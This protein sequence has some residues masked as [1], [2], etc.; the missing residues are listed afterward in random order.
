M[1]RY[2]LHPAVQPLL[3]AT[4]LVLVTGWIYWPGVSGPALLDDRSSVLVLQDLEERPEYAWDYVFGNR[5]GRLG[6]PVSMVTF[7]LERVYLDGTIATSKRVNIV[8]HLCNGALVMWLFWL[9][10]R[11]WAVPGYRGLA[12]VL[13]AIWLLHPLL[14]STVL[15]VVQRMAM[16]STFF[17]LLSAISYVY[18]RTALGEGRGSV[19]RFLPVP[20]CLLL[21]LFAKENAI[22]LIPILLLMEVLWFGCR[23]PAGATIRWL[24]RVSVSLI[25]GGAVFVAALLLLGWDGLAHRMRGRPFTLDE[26]LLT[27]SRIVWDYVSQWV[28]PQVARMGIYHDDVP[29]SRSLLE[30]VTTLYATL[31]WAAVMVVCAVLLR[32][33]GGRWWVFGFA[34]FLIGHS[35]ESTVFSLELYYEHRNYFPSI[36]LVLALGVPFALLVNRW[37]EPRL[38]L[39]VCLGLVALVLSALTSSQAVIWS[40]RPLLAL[41]H[42]NG[43]P[44][45][46]RANIEMAEQVARLGD[47]ASAHRYSQAAFESSAGGAGANELIGDYQVRNL[48]LNC[49]ANSPPSPAQ[50]EALALVDPRR[51]LQSVAA[52]RALVRLLQGGACPR[53]DRVYV[54]DWLARLYLGDDASASASAKIYFDLAL[55]ENALARYDKAFAYT[56]RFLAGAPG[57]TRGLLMKLHFATATGQVEAAEDA[58]GRLQTMQ[59]E[60]T[61]TLR[62]QQTLALYL[63]DPNDPGRETPR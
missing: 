11:Y 19:L 16:L 26:R 58:I 39:L 40:S 1:S 24:Q 47:I 48:A 44:G 36:G 10:F 63:N 29:L 28:Y 25:A 18:W 27:Q 41:H 22:V 30:P 43:H 59:R 35:I 37:P 38:A 46:G 14:V 53:F 17:M 12:V 54:A 33:Q 8:V 23:T 9:L 57:D 20:V 56:E 21:G 32:W 62:A 61:L 4:V 31:A 2:L 52:L 13:G 55:L 50:L 6:R 42:I 7:V 5:S 3:L 51:P 34:W 15:Y 60:G 45:S 49:I